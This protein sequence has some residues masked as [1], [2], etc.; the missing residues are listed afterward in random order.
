[1][2]P[3]NLDEADNVFDAIAARSAGDSSPAKLATLPDA[4]NDFSCVK[5]KNKIKERCLKLKNF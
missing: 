1:M 4:F 3:V 5:K 2:T